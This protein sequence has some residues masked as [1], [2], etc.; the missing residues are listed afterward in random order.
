MWIIEYDIDLSM[1]S[2]YDK[3]IK[4]ESAIL[5]IVP[6]I[7]GASYTYSATYTYSASYMG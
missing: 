7:G 2:N 6:L 1:I 5:V 4:I 3:N